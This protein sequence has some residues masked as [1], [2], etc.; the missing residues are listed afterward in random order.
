MGTLTA[1]E[2]ER[3]DLFAELDEAARAQWA[4]AAT[5]REVAPGEPIAEQ[6]EVAA[7]FH[8]LL[9]G[10][11]Q[12]LVIEDGRTEPVGDHVAPTWVG[13]IAALTA[14]PL[15]VRM[16][17]LTPMRVADIPAEQFLELAV[18]HRPVF[19]R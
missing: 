19:Q 16:V 3:F 18:A 10:T 12:A 6:A 15:G 1:A 4:A 11:A 7:N 2:L 5:V 13:A 14:A 8:L 9:E 17:A